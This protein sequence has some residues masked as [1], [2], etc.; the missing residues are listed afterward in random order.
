MV[1]PPPRAST[2]GSV[3]AM[4]AP[5]EPTT[6]APFV[7]GG[8]QRLPHLGVLEHAAEVHRRAAAQVDE[9]GSAA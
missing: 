1:S 5:D 3:R 4:A 6:T 9:P 7:P 8:D 2:I